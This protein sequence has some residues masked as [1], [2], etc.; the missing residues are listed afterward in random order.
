MDLERISVKYVLRYRPIVCPCIGSVRRS[1]APMN[2]TE[3]PDSLTETPS[4]ANH[5]S[6]ASP[7]EYTTA[8]ECGRPTLAAGHEPERRMLLTISRVF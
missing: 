7:R 6:K 5:G 2:R 4:H 1:E 3:N 8:A